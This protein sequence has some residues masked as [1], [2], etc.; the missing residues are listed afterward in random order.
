MYVA[1]Y[2]IGH[3]WGT[4]SIPE[5]GLLCLINAASIAFTFQ[6]HMV[7]AAKWCCAQLGWASLTIVACGLLY[8]VGEPICRLWQ[9]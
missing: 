5:T 1:G 4:I 8:V 9:Y 3:F 2:G 7:R 6:V